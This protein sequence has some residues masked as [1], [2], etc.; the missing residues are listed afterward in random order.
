VFISGKYPTFDENFLTVLYWFLCQ[1]GSTVLMSSEPKKLITMAETLRTI[2]FPFEY[3]DS[4]MP[5]MSKK[6]YGYLSAPFPMLIGVVVSS[7]KD[8]ELVESLASDKSLLVY[9]D[10]CDENDKELDATSLRVKLYEE[11]LTVKDFKRE[12]DETV[13]KQYC[14][15]NFP[16]KPLKELKKEMKKIRKSAD[17]WIKEQ[18]AIHLKIKQQK[19]MEIRETFLDFFVTMF[20]DYEECIKKEIGDKGDGQGESV[21]SQFFQSQFLKKQNDKYDFF[22]DLFNTRAWLVFLE[23][24][25]YSNTIE[26]QSEREFFDR[27]IEE[28]YMSKAEKHKQKKNEIE[29][30]EEKKELKREQSTVQKEGI[31]TSYECHI[32]TI[33]SSSKNLEEKYLNTKDKNGIPYSCYTESILERDCQDFEYLIIPPFSKDSIP[34]VSNFSKDRFAD[35]L[36]KDDEMIWSDQDMNL[37]EE[38]QLKNDEEGIKISWVIMWCLCFKYLNKNEKKVRLFELTKVLETLFKQKGYD[39]SNITFLEYILQAIH[40]HG[41]K[42]HMEVLFRTI[43]D[44]SIPPNLRMKQYY[45]RCIDKEKLSGADGRKRNKNRN[46]MDLMGDTKKEEKLIYGIKKSGRLRKRTLKSY[47]ERRNLLIEEVVTFEVPGRCPNNIWRK[48]SDMGQLFQTAEQGKDFRCFFC[49]YRMLLDLYVIIGYQSDLEDL[50]TWIE[51]KIVLNNPYEIF[52]NVKHL[53]DTTSSEDSK[54]TNGFDLMILREHRANLLWNCILQ[55]KMNELPFDFI[56]PFEDTDIKFKY[57]KNNKQYQ[58]KDFE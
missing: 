49:G 34:T 46:R 58:I 56:L 28:K 20:K 22:E 29:G 27:K 35:N 5:V 37:L 41:K 8:I 51:Y 43:K 45:F 23:H 25:F 39:K 3:D 19:V 52:F 18:S 21:P 14:L 4:Y 31:S 38:I 47:K 42:E 55:F 40:E 26:Q 32:N 53:Y 44:C 36:W 11:L 9:L 33:F 50:S 6:N 16:S 17:L 7:E 10:R 57:D 2:I 48:N 30:E 15:K 1:V 54:S 24:K 12:Y 13:R